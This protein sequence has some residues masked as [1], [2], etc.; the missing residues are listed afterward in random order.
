MK[1][2]LVIILALLFNWSFGQPKTIRTYQ[3]HELDKA[4]IDS[5]L[6]IQIKG[7]KL[8]KIPNEI[9]RF[10]NLQY[11]DLSNNKL[12][13]VAGLTAFSQLKKI[14]VSRNKLEYFPLDFCQLTELD[15]IIINRNTSIETI[16]SC[17]QYCKKL[18]YL[19]LWYTAIDVLPAELATIPN[20]KKIDLTGV[21]INRAK[22]DKLRETFKNIQL[23]LS[24]PCNCVN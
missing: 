24:P 13:D 9:F 5:V 16:P 1:Y 6:S 4:P 17:M 12:T 21:Q 3:W 15:S 11:L 19:D 10:K 7:K 20:L 8:T 18:S 23:I 22:Q 14:D 2:T